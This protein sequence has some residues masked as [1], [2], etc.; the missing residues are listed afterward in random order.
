MQ[1]L[2]KTAGNNLVKLPN[3]IEWSL[4]SND[5]YMRTQKNSLGIPSDNF[6]VA[7]RGLDSHVCGRLVARG[8]NSSPDCCSVPLILQVLKKKRKQLP[9][10]NCFLLAKMDTFDTKNFKYHFT[11]NLNLMHN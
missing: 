8:H 5:T 2:H 10:G 6:T 3:C 7:G 9:D 4:R 1:I 11:Q